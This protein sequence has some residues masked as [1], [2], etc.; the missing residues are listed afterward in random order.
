[1]GIR[2]RRRK[3]TTT[4]STMETRLKSVELRPISLLTTEQINA[5]VTI[6]ASTTPDRF[7]IGDDAPNTYNIIHDAYY[8]PKKLTG[9]DNDL[10]EIYTQGSLSL[11]VDKR[12]EISGIH[13]TVDTAIDVTSDNFTV[14]EVE[15][16][17]WTGR[18][19]YKHD[20]TQDQLPTVVIGYAYSVVPET[21]APSSLST[22]Q[23]L[24]TRATINTFSIT[25]TTVT[26]N[27]TAN[28]RFKVEDVVYVNLDEDGAY[29]PES[30]TAYGTDGI[31]K[32]TAVTSNSLSYVLPAGVGSPTGDINPTANVYVFATARNWCDVGDTWIDTSGAE[33]TTYYWSGLRW[34]EFTATTPGVG[35]D[36]TP[37]AP[38]SNVAV[39]ALE[40][41]G[42]TDSSG[43]PRARITLNWDAPTL[44]ANG[45]PLTD[46]V[47]YE[48]WYSYVSGSE[49]IKSGVIIGEEKYTASNLDPARTV[50]FQVYAVDSS[51]NRSTAVNFNTVSGTFAAVLNPPSAPILASDLGVI[52]ARW[53]GLDNGGLNPHPSI[54]L[55]ETHVSPTSGFTPSA[56]TR[57]AS[58]SASTD[59]YSSIYQY[60]DG[61]GNLINMSYSTDYYFKFVAVDSS[62]N[63]TA[64]STQA[65]GQISQVDGAAIQAGAISAKILAGETI[66]A[67]SNASVYQ[68]ELNAN[69]LRAVHKIN[70]TETFKM[71]S[72]D[73]AVT[74]G[75]GITNTSING[76]AITVSNLSANSITTGTLNASNVTV[77][78]LSANSITTGTLNGTN[79]T[80]TNLSASSITTGTFSGNRVSGGTITGTTVTGGTFI[81]SGTRRVEISGT[82]A[83]FY[84]SNGTLSGRVTAGEDGRAATMY[85]GT[86]VTGV[87]A[88]NGG[89][90]LEANGPV[91]VTGGNG[92]TSS[93][94][95]TAG[96]GLTVNGAVGTLNQGLT[97][98]GAVGTFNAG[99]AVNNAEADFNAGLWTT[100]VDISTGRLSQDQA[101]GRIASNVGLLSNG[102]M[103]VTGNFTYVAAIDTGTTFPLYWKSGGT[104]LVYRLSSSRRYKTDIKDAE[105]DYDALLA[106]RIRTFKNKKDAEEFGIENV[107]LTYGYIAEELH[108][109]GLTDFVVYENDEDG[110]PRPESVNYMSMAM[111]THSIVKLQ[112][113]K[114][115]ELENTLEA[116]ISRIEALESAQ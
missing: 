115:K 6:G 99:L 93:G 38:V 21:L 36:S 59:N 70:G 101:S 88:Y 69:H 22:R 5:A 104:N 97:V 8:Y 39:V 109:L 91:Q 94:P 41:G 63:R 74:I 28:H 13:G 86:D 7:F 58:M 89:L 19:S 53:N 72:S 108:D 35:G 95:I 111:A 29:N 116:L 11:S 27:T 43:T 85:F 87:F 68:I 113:S 40:S 52:T 107:E 50:Y 26:I 2:R 33:D 16:S 75:A 71:N 14:A 100:Y 44:D 10:V 73:G 48:V 79:V 34:A 84:D 61:T 31:F 46:L 56:N 24:E 110:N 103:G 81:T 45:N 15:E 49:W 32:L 18:A 54:R 25:N 105:F 92:L 23:R 96:N 20:P 60:N 83:N 67:T 57:V 64:G 30:T 51:L 77:T 4:L 12:I 9:K 98:G 37:P 82:N 66:V 55:I 17:P 1:M 102:P 65:V 76:S 42:Y 80:V 114:I 78:N 106:V 47:G 62:G 3:L 90:D 112:D